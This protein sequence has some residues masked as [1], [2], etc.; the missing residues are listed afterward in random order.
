MTKNSSPSSKNTSTERKFVFDKAHAIDLVKDVIQW[1]VVTALGFI[2]WMAV[3]LLAS[4]FLLNIW[5]VSFTT[6]L[7][8]GIG[9]TAITGVVYAIVM[10]RRNINR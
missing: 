6:I 3:L 1:L 9:L 8:Y 2:Y 5:H 4:V 7:K 10:H